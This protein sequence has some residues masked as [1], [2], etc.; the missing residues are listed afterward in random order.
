MSELRVIGRDG[1]EQRLEALED[2]AVMETL[3]DAGTGILGT[4][5][6]ACSCGT[7][8]VYVAPEWLDRLPSKG[9]DE[10]MMLEA[11]GELVPLRS[12]SRLACQLPMTAALS[13]L[14]LEIAPEL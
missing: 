13:G 5:G 6:G 12:G 10:T 2:V 7:C 11:I 14:V 8:H 1:S 4:C 9:E 3:R